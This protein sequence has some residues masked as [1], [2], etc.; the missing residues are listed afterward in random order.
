MNSLCHGWFI[1]N[2]HPKKPNNQETTVIIGSISFKTITILLLKCKLMRK[3]LTQNN[4]W[5]VIRFKLKN[6]R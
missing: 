2:L 6:D 3:N 5:W 4:D 1:A